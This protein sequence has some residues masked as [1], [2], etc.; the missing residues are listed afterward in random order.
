MKAR[1][2][3][4]IDGP[5]EPQESAQKPKWVVYVDG[6]R[7]SK[8]VGVGIMIQGPNQVNMEYALRVEADTT[9]FFLGSIIPY[10]ERVSSSS[11][12]ITSIGEVD[13][14]RLG[15][16]TFDKASSLACLEAGPEVSESE[17][18][19]AGKTGIGYDPG[20]QSLR[21]TSCLLNRGR[22]LY[23]MAATSTLVGFA[24]F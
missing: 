15:A 10:A 12:E 1:Q 9:F 19:L 20:R 13:G 16:F 14:V 2:P 3:L 24:S 7:N 11:R 8:G 21:T 22:R 17:A 18:F 5:K 4:R 6:A 23:F